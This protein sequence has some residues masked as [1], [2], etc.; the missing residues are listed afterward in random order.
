[1]KK[2]ISLI[3]TSILVL[4]VFV[5][6]DMGAPQI[7]P[8]EAVIKNENGVICKYYDYGEHTIQIPYDTKVKVIYEYESDNTLTSEIE[9]ENHQ[10]SINTKDLMPFLSKLIPEEH[11]D[12]VFK[13]ENL[14][15]A[16][17]LSKT[18]VAVHTGPSQAYEKIGTIPYETK[19]EYLY[20]SGTDGTDSNPLWIYIKYN[21]I[22]G[23]ISTD[24]YN[25]GLYTLNELLI[26][27]KTKI[28]DTIFGDQKTLGT[29]EAFTT[30]KEYYSLSSSIGNYYVEYNGINGFI[31]APYVNVLETEKTIK[32]EKKAYIYDSIND[33]E[34]N[35]IKEVPARTEL[36]YK[37]V[38]YGNG[39]DY[40][41]ITYQGI[42]G[43]M[44]VTYY[45]DSTEEEQTTNPIEEEQITNPIKDETTTT[46]KVEKE[47]S[48]LSG[49]EVVILCVAA[50]LLLALTITVIIILINKKKTKVVMPEQIVDNNKK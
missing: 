47:T 27:D 30:L 23:W 32:L 21:N 3:L 22:E 20:S 50:S 26:P 7:D 49:K 17:I 43:W 45:D 13:E 44:L 46:K 5:H 39:D 35:K 41:Y 36:Q 37:Y 8:Y 24:N 28:T 12:K 6:A 11:L 2:I 18:G 19:L 48:Q 9:Y 33:L 29:I 38:I 15:T 40:Y 16:K 34:Q 31:Y 10:C 4:P 14:R 1:M 42:T 25:I